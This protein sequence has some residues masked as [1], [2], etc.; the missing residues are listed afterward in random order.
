[1]PA[2]SNSPSRLK[3]GTAAGLILVTTLTGFEGVRT[4]A[5]PDPATGGKPWTICMG[6]TQG[7]HP[8]MVKTLVDCKADL[9]ATI[10]K[11]AAPIAQCAKVPLPDKRYIALVSLAWNIGPGKVCSGEVMRQ[12]NKGNVKAGCEA[13]MKYVYAA[14]IKFP[15][16]VSRRVKERAMCLEPITTANPVSVGVS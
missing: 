1:M 10:P 3:Q 7:V 11:Y 5:Y 8:G 13:F 9:Y 14:G 15:G 16:L 2:Q 4:R 6:Q 12:L